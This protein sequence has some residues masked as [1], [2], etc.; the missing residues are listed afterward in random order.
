LPTLG[1][2]VQ[3]VRQSII[4]ERSTSSGVRMSYQ[5][6]PAIAVA[7]DVT[8]VVL[9]SVLGQRC[10]QL[11]VAKPMGPL[12]E[13]IGIGLVSGILFAL[14]ARLAGLHRIPVLSAPGQYP[15]RIVATVAVGQLAMIC[16]L[17][18]LKV[19]DEYSRGAMIAFTAFAAG[20]ALLGRF[21]LAAASRH[22][23]RRGVLT[24]RRVV[25]LGD[26]GEL[27]RLAESDFQRFGIDDIARIPIGG[28][29]NGLGEND[30]ARVAHAIAISRQLRAA[31]FALFMPWSRDRELA[32][33]C[34]LLRNSPLPVRLYPDQKIRGVFRRQMEG[35]VDQRFSVIVQ[36]APLSVGERALKRAA[37]LVIATTAL[38]GLAPL[39]LAISLLIKL[40]SRGP[41]IFRQRRCGFDD[42]IFVIFKFRTMTVLED[43]DSIVQAKQTDGRVTR[44]GKFFRRWSLD[45][46]PQLLNVI[47]GDMSLVGPR[48]HAVAH[49]DEFKARISNYALRHHVKPGLTGAAQ[50]AGL[51]GETAHLSQMEQRVERDLWYINNWSPTLD[52][53]LMAMTCGALFRF[54]AY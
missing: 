48:P 36:R 40:D 13:L 37:D 20:F 45:E 52:L 11:Y 44:I 27:E 7:V 46:L 41:V 42:R 51:R 29:A 9:A 32:D 34:G 38:V 8:F 43:G 22:G 3:I 6:L 14:L 21:I 30:R 49:D 24:R 17:F 54:D 50:V 47:R 39:F 16:I 10:Y 33:V 23:V 28:D 31:E 2:T 4:V 26:P 18:L 35:D 53:K 1:A 19:G 5:A 15:A 25:A 12:D